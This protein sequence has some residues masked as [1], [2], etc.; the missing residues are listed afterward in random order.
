MRQGAPELIEQFNLFVNNS[1][2]GNSIPTPTLRDIRMYVCNVCMYVR[3]YV[4]TY[5]GMYVCNV[6]M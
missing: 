2:L 6:C 3:M 4:R 5:V 1:V